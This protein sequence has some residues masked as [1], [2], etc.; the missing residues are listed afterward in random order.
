MTVR[1]YVAIGANLGDAKATV[2]QA[3]DALDALPQTRVA[4]RSSLYRSAPFEASGPDFINAVAA[5]DTGLDA[6]ALLGAMQ[7]LEL[8]A[9]RERP[10]RNAPRTLDLDLLQHG[11]DALDT[12]TLTL[13]HPRMTQRAFVMLPLAEIAPELVTPQQLAAVA[14]QPI[15]RL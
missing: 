11:D 15:E 13:P 1:A 9:G 8:Q 12:P 5:L 6:H 10:Y 4:A 14:G 2:Q 7:Q 3:I